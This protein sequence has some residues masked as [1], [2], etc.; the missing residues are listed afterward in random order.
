MTNN[1]HDVR[2]LFIHGGNG[3]SGEDQTQSPMALYLSRKFHA[4]TV[5]MNTSLYEVCKKQQ[6]EAIAT[7]RPD[8][9]AGISFGGALLFDLIRSH[10]WS[11]LSL[12][13]CPALIPGLDELSLDK[14]CTAP[15]FLCHGSSDK[16]VP[17]AVSQKIIEANPDHPHL[18][19][20]E[21]VNDTHSLPSLLI[22]PGSAENNQG[23]NLESL[24][25]NLWE[26][27]EH[28][29][30]ARPGHTEKEKNVH[31]KE[32]KKCKIM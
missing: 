3:N 31:T 26:L 6:K 20:T 13:M 18:S 10:E 12:V 19:L 21:V 7:F 14:A 4:H 25:L 2:V 11:G 23:P 9:I 16:V 1:A 15:I 29:P 32:S 24:I 22:E 30:V 5:K 28:V 27:R 8:I 17:I